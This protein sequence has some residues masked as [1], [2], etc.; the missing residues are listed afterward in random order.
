MGRYGA[1]VA[2]Y[3]VILRRIKEMRDD[4]RYGNQI[5]Q[6][7]FIS[8]GKANLTIKTPGMYN[9]IV[10]TLLGCQGMQIR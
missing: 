9:L 4:Q 6:P 8:T 3:S 1:P 5:P 10:K 7:A 2:R